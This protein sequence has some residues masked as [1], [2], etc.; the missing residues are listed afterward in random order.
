M[1][2]DNSEEAIPSR[3]QRPLL[4]GSVVIGPLND[5]GTGTGRGAI[6]IQQQAAI[7]ANNVIGSRAIVRPLT[8]RSINAP[9]CMPGHGSISPA[10]LK[11]QPDIWR[12]AQVAWGP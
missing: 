11:W 4:I 8:C 5:L 9:G 3:D 7:P 12:G 1:L 6:D 2:I 10:Y